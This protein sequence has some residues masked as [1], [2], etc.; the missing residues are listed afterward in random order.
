MASTSEFPSLAGWK[1]GIGGFIELLLFVVLFYA[2]VFYE[3]MM[4]GFRIIPLKLVVMIDNRII[5]TWF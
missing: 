4:S 3:G 2:I 1:D 5:L